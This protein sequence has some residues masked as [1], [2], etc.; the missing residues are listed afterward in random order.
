MITVKNIKKSYGAEGS[1]L[2][3]LRGVSCEFEAGEKCA[4]VGSSGSGKS[5]LLNC[6]SGLESIDE[7]EII[8][9]GTEIHRLG[10]EKLRRFRK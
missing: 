8:I 10:K 7:G 1:K 6:I 5:T 2:Y 3:A 4:I 9:N